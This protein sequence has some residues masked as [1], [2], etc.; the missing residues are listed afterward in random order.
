VN[1][2]A[3]DPEHHERKRTTFQ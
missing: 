3:R 1:Y 2:K